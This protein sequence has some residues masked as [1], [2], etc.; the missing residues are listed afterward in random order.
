MVRLVSGGAIVR[1]VAT[2]LAVTLNLTS[3]LFICRPIL[4]QAF[5]TIRAS[6]AYIAS[7]AVTSRVT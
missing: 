5:V 4:Q 6:K 1:T 2:I 7:S 3:I